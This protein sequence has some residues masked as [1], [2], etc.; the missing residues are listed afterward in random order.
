METRIRLLGHPVHGMLVV[1]PLGLFPAA[2]LFD[3]LYLATGIAEFAAVA[4]WNISIGIVGGLLAAPFGAIDWSAIPSAT[5]A[6]RI[7]RWHGGGNLLILGLFT[8][9]WLMRQP[10]HAYAPNAVPFLL[11]L[12]GG[13]LAL[14]T[15]WLG[16]ELVYRLRMAVDDEASLNAS[17]S[18]GRG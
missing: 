15:G 13:G 3:A 9:S 7:G 11:G 2:V 4:Y 5:R 12:T 16:G 10:N 17:N 1:L 6:K 8:V 14:V 18:I